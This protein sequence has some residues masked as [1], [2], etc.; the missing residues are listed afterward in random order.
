MNRQ[1]KTT[2]LTIYGLIMAFV[3]LLSACTT[4]T[5]PAETYQGEA[6][7]QIFQNGEQALRKGNYAEAIK[8]FEALDVQYPYGDHTELAQLH[9]IY[10][11]YKNSDYL[12]SEAAADRFIRTHSGSAHVDYAYFMRGI[13]NYYQNIGTIERMF[14]VNYAT[15][16]LTQMKKSYNDFAELSRQFPQSRYVPAAHQYMIYLRNTLANH[17]LEVA[18]FYYDKQAYVAAANRATQVV[19]HY[20]GAPAVPKALVMMAH[21]YR[22]LRM[23]QSEHEALKVLEYNYPNSIYLTDALSH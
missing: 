11:Y 4:A 2:K 5:D 16:D 10:A 17:Q 3:F 20:Q 19:E 7:N 6:A 22:K 14:N 1:M 18:Q 9:I 15:R 8:R 12:S 21:S 23:A 13:A